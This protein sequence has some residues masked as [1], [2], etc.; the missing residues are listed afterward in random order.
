MVRDPRFGGSKPNAPGVF[1][2]GEWRSCPGYEGLYAVSI[3]GRVKRVARGP[4][5]CPGKVKKLQ[6]APTRQ[7]WTVKLHKNGTGQ[8]V[9]VAPLVCK[10][11]HGPAPSHKHRVGHKDG[12]RCNDHASNL[13]WELPD[14]TVRRSYSLGKINRNGPHNGRAKLNRAS[15]KEIRGLQGHCTAA[16]IAQRHEVSEW[17]VRAIWEGKRWKGES[18]ESKRTG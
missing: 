14:A 15:V 11:F 12:N 4:N 1:T 16:E 3:E 13:C 7:R 9:D 2:P 17:T 8:R 10:A 5:T 6:R 18:H